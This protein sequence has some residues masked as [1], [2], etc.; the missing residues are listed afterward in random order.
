MIA[1]EIAIDHLTEM[2]DYYTRLNKM[3]D[4]AKAQGDTGEESDKSEKEM[5]DILLGYEPKN[6]GDNVDEELT[7]YQKDLIN[8]IPDKKVTIP[9]PKGLG[10]T[11]YQQK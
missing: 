1:M 8:K 9:V 4:D 2:P 5:E 3:E 11:G 6:V 7:D 10:K